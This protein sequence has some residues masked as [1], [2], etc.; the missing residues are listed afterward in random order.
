MTYAGN[1]TVPVVEGN[2]V[3]GQGSEHRDLLLGV[4]VHDLL[5]QEGR[6]GLAAVA[7][8]LLLD[9]TLHARR[10]A[11]VRVEATEE[12]EV[13]AVNVVIWVIYDGVVVRSLT[14]GLSERRVADVQRVAVGTALDGVLETLESL[15]AE[16]VV[17]RTVLHD[18][19]DEVLDALLEVVGGFG[20]LWRVGR[21]WGA[22]HGG[23]EGE[24]SEC[25]GGAHSE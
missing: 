20:G 10:L 17:E 7:A 4:V 5:T 11:S 13:V 23:R 3:L 12:L 1:V 21:C 18:K 22:A 19:D 2:E 16:E 8:D 6:V 25:C 14:A 24:K 9:E 15:P